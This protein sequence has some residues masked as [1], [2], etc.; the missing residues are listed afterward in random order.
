MRSRL[1]PFL[2]RVH[3]N[4][5]HLNRGHDH[6]RVHHLPRR[7][8]V[9]HSGVARGMERVHCRREH[10]H[11]LLAMAKMGQGHHARGHGP[12]PRPHPLAP[13]SAPAEAS[14]DAA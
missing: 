6:P 8:G 10:G 4:R 13:P 7:H 14:R 11:H 2:N 3:L 9:H 1:L 5:V 12:G